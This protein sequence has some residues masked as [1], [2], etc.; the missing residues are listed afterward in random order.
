MFKFYAVWLIAAILRSCFSVSEVLH[1][2]SFVLQFLKYK[3][4]SYY[5]TQFMI[6][7]HAFWF[8]F[9]FYFFFVRAAEDN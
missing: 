1:M 2:L 4:S 8:V 5:N 9:D 3:H 7:K 6:L